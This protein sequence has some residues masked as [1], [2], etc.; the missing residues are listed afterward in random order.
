MRME[1]G[2]VEA[3][4]KNG[5]EVRW[6]RRGNPRAKLDREVSCERKETR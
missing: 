1:R 4:G 2:D 6:W 3:G 5:N